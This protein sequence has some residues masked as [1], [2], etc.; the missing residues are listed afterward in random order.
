MRNEEVKAGNEE[1]NAKG[2][3]FCHPILDV[4]DR[5]C[6]IFLPVVDETVT[7]QVETRGGRS[8]VWTRRIQESGR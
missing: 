4:C 8:M 5:A 1:M 7:M 3:D 6:S 2:K